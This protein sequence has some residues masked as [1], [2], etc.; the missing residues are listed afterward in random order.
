MGLDIEKAYVEI[1]N[2]EICV[3]DYYFLIKKEKYFN[4]KDIT[5]IEVVLGYSS[6]LR[7]YRLNAGG[8]QYIVFK[9]SNNKYLFKIFII[10]FY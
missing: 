4:V 10:C 8:T 1:N 2:D 7:G 6:K 3:V 9:N 5:K